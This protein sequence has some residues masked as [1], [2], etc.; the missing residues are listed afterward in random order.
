[1]VEALESVYDKALD[2]V[3]G[4]SASVDSVAAE[5]LSR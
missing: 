3:P 1:M 2:G 4:V 5:Y